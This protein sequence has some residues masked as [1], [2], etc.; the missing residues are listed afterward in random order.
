MIPFF[1]DE[2]ETEAD[3]AKC[4]VVP[5]GIKSKPQLL[6]FLSKAIPLPDYFGKNWDALEECLADLK[7]SDGEI[8]LSHQDIPMAGSAT[9]QKIYLEILAALAAQPLSPVRVHFLR[10][11]EPQ[12]ESL[13]SGGPRS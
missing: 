1:F 8:I 3:G 7:P 13:L 9:E 11:D 10:T 6:S 4:V 5:A 2:P 12:I